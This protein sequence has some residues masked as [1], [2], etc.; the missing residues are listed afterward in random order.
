[1]RAYGNEM[2]RNY[3]DLNALLVWY[4]KNG[5]NIELKQWAAKISPE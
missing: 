5:D 1:M 4:V 3:E 2:L